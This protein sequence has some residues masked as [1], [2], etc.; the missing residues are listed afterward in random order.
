MVVAHYGM[1]PSGTCE[2]VPKADA[3]KREPWLLLFAN[4][5]GS[6]AAPPVGG[7]AKPRQTEVA[8]TVSG[9]RLGESTQGV[10]ERI[11]R[12]WLGPVGVASLHT[13]RVYS[14]RGKGGG[15]VRTWISPVS[16][17]SRKSMTS[18]PPPVPPHVLERAMGESEASKAAPWTQ[19]PHRSPPKGERAPDAGGRVAR[20]S[21]RSRG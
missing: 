7:V 11:N 15:G 3:F 1:C 6:G 2:G 18:G 13:P 17:R 4:P 21:S 8:L 16:A 20:P 10:P 9:G 5:R 19:P 14:L 12:L